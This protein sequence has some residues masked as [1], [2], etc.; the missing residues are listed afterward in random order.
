MSSASARTRSPIRTATFGGAW[1][2]GI[3]VSLYDVSNPSEPFETD[4]VILG[5]RGSEAA[6]LQ[7]HR[8]LTFLQPVDGN[9]RVTIGARV[10]ERIEPGTT[11][12]PW[13]YFGWS[14]SGLHLFEIDTVAGHIVR[15]GE[16][17]VE[18]YEPTPDGSGAWPRVFDGDRS[19]MSGDAVFFVHGD[20]IYT[21]LW[22][23][24][25]VFEG[26]R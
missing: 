7:D 18:E 26:P 17:R 23:N 6:I 3:K 16:M 21:S 25:G 10:H 20:D 9:L 22:S 4:A 13:T 5:K 1:Y 15:R 11:I 8:A 14:Y 19:V 24:P 2:Q 12:Y